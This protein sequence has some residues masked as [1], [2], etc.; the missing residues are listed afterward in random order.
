MNNKIKKAE[1]KINTDLLNDLGYSVGVDLSN[2][3]HDH[4]VDVNVGKTY[5]APFIISEQEF[6]EYGNEE[7]TLLLYADKVLATEDDEIVDDPESIL[8]NCLDEF[9]EY[10]EVM[11]VRNGNTETDYI[12]L[13]SEKNFSDINTEV[14]E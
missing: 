9:E 8:G 12:I 1:E 10:D 3:E 7:I 13:R 6:G 5:D 2:E 11:Y 4:M 14:D